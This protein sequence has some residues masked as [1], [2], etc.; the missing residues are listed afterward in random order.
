MPTTIENRDRG[1]PQRT[2]TGQFRDAVDRG[3]THDKIAVADPATAPVHTDAEA[4]GRGTPRAASTA[5]TRAPEQRPP[6]E[7]VSLDFTNPGR[8]QFQIPPRRMA[9][10]MALGLAFLVLFGLAAAVVTLP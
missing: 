10:A 6:P 2:D 1:R 5:A 9:W 7:E 8:A 3:R 4:G